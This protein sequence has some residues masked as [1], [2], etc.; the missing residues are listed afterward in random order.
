M[1]LLV[2]GVVLVLAALVN[3]VLG[4]VTA[5][6]VTGVVGLMVVLVWLFRRYGRPG[7]FNRS[8]TTGIQ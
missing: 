2:I 5:A 6:V 8:G 1:V 7:D 4:H 3:L